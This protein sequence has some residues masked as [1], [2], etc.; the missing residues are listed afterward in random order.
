MTCFA[1]DISSAGRFLQAKEAAGKKAKKAEG[2]PGSS[3]KAA[4]DLLSS[5]SARD[6]GESF[7]ILT[8]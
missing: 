8:I 7:K 4:A 5:H 3:K 2:T 6:E 1:R